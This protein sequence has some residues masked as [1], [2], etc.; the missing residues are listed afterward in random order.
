M[1]DLY[2]VKKY[3]SYDFVQNTKPS[4]TGTW[5]VS[6][7]FFD[8]ETYTKGESYNVT[9]VSPFTAVRIET[10]E[11]AKIEANLHHTLKLVLDYL[12]NFFYE[13]RQDFNVSF[14]YGEW[15]IKQSLINDNIHY[16]SD[17]NQYEFKVDGEIDSLS[18]DIFEVGDLIRIAGSLRNDIVGYIES[19]SP[20]KITNKDLRATTEYAIL[21]LCNIPKQ[22][23]EII[24]QM[25][26][27]DT[28]KRKIKDKKAERIGNYSY[29]KDDTF[30]K[31]GGLEY[32]SYLINQL[33][34][35]KLVRIVQ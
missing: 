14:D 28:F 21:F 19:L 10:S 4:S 9:S 23:E 1:I 5:L 8:V 7:T 16:L 15:D 2:S 29:Q 13:I 11:D 3:S 18:E 32:P 22:V 33:K 34:P 35:Y 30:L 12:N 6:E 17:M 31:I 26:Y 24:S 27:F 20:L 25:L